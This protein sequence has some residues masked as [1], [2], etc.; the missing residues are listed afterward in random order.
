[1]CGFFILK[2]NL[3][4][5]SEQ[6][7]L[8]TRA[9][10]RMHHRGPDN[11]SIYRL[12]GFTFGHVR[13]SIQDLSSDANQPF[14]SNCGRYV[15]CF[16]GEIYNAKRLKSI[17]VDNGVSFRTLNSDTEVLLYWLISFHTTRLDD[18][19]GEWSFFFYD[20]VTSSAILCRDRVG[21]KPLYFVKNDTS[22][23]AS[24]ELKP[25]IDTQICKNEISSAGLESYLVNGA[26]AAPYTLI[27]GIYKLGAGQILTFSKDSFKIMSWWSHDSINA[28]SLPQVS[29][30]QC[31]S[32]VID[33]VLSR[34]I[35]DVPYGILFSGG[36]DSSIIASVISRNVPDK[37]HTFTVGFNPRPLFDETEKAK[38]LSKLFNTDHHE[39]ILSKSS[40]I[41]EINSLISK[42]DVPLSD[43]V[44]LPLYLIARKAKQEGFSVLI[45]GEGAD[46]LFLGYS[47][48]FR[49]IALDLLCT[50]INPFY[51]I[52]AKF[53]I[54]KLIFRKYFPRTCYQ[55]LTILKTFH[56]YHSTFISNSLVFAPHEL[57]GVSDKLNVDPYL[58]KSKSST[59][60]RI[61]SAEFKIRLPELLLMRVDSMT[62]LNSVETRVPFL[63]GPL[64]SAILP[65]NVFQL[66]P[67]FKPKFFLKKAFSDLPHSILWT[68]KIGFGT[69]IPDW[70][71]GDFKSSLCLKLSALN[72]TYKLFSTKWI[73]V[74]ILKTNSNIVP[75]R[76]RSVWQLWT[77]Y[78][79]LTWY[80]SLN[81]PLPNTK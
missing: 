55:I 17:L 73:D 78:I 61:R 40:A 28:N 75:L 66:S 46:E 5:P 62:M 69:P 10:E 8:V 24:S 36:V 42:Y 16:N 58:Y 25:I 20:S 43:W 13:L 39:F 49:Y 27:E 60:D 81:D 21:T 50:A 32:L 77:I 2:S 9:L 41:T 1:M 30:K 12:D 33:S 19:D 79:L 68:R 51:N 72:I 67:W 57:I 14:I 53:E 6:N 71:T 70:F 34:T 63:S 45:A 64:L 3:L 15:L 38:N 4:P 54:C 22:F 52:L 47:A 76:N 65:Q 7:N 74:L 35:C 80:D 11:L 18:L 23:I 48:Y 26:T 56:L 29:L 37:C 31:K 44:N 59:L